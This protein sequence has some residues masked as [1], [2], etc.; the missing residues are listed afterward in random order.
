MG[1]ILGVPFVL[2]ISKL[3][4]RV[5]GTKSKVSLGVIG[6]AFC[7]YIELLDP[8]KNAEIM[9]GLPTFRKQSSSYMV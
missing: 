9:H 8:Q 2:D 5:L 4:G 3:L 7:R 1:F 6:F